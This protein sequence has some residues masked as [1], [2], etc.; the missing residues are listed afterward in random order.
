[1]LHGVHVDFPPAQDWWRHQLLACSG[2]PFLHVSP[3]S[4]LAMATTVGTDN[5]TLLEE[6]E[7]VSQV[8]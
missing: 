3:P 8:V 2:S 5:Q 4:I 1:M 7:L 6:K